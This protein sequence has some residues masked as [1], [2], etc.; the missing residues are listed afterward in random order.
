MNWNYFL[1]DPLSWDE[2][3]AWWDTREERALDIALS[4]FVIT[5]LVIAVNI[6]SRRLLTR[7]LRTFVTRAEKAKSTDAAL[8]KRRADTVAGTMN[9]AI[10][11]F[12]GII[13]IGLVLGEFGFD[14]TTLI[15]GIGIV[16]IGLGLGAQL[17]VRDV[18]NGLFILMEDQYGVGD[19][20]KVAGVS[21]QV[22]DVNPRRTVLRDLD[23]NVH[24]VPNSAITV[25]T[26]MT[27]GF[28]RINLDI[29]VAYEEDIDRVV[30]VINDVGEKLAV[31]RAEDILSTPK[32][33]RVDGF[34]EN[35][36][37]IKVVGDVR[38][39]MQWELSGELRKRIKERF[40]AESIEIP[41]PHRVSI[42]RGES[43][44][45]PFPSD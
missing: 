30:A 35:G 16:G 21:G 43:Q 20:V 3:R 41:Y 19:I 23:G 6:V 11:I 1:L 18:L 9:W 42:V 28:S 12:V 34:A 26:N 38:V 36:V 25:A 39:F 24:V 45:G 29:G 8:I 37:T 31:D 22:V 7:A 2:W 10:G 14:L 5:V 40:D 13:A 27:Q 33:L 17:L 15:A 4:L 44:R 32:V